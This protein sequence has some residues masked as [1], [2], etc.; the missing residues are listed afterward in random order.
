VQLPALITVAVL[1]A[2]ALPSSRRSGETGV[3]AT[4]AP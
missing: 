3:A 4:P 1:A 2:S